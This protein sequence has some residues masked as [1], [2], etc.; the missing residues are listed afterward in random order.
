MTPRQAAANEVAQRLTWVADE[1]DL[2]NKLEDGGADLVRDLYKFIDRVRAHGVGRPD[3]DADAVTTSI[4][5]GA[6]EIE[7]IC[8][9]TGLTETNVRKIVDGLI[10]TGVAEM[11]PRRKGGRDEETGGAQAMMISLVETPAGSNLVLP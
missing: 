3:R 6:S 5:E 1:S 8:D 10:A 2:W 11:R 4:R 7:E 9:D